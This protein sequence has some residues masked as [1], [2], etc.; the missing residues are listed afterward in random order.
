MMVLKCREKAGMFMLEDSFF[1]PRR[2]WKFIKL[3]QKFLDVRKQILKRPSV[4]NDHLIHHITHVLVIT[5]SSMHHTNQQSWQQ[6]NT[7]HHIHAHTH[8]QGKVEK[9]RTRMQAH[10]RVLAEISSTQE[11]IQLLNV[12]QSLTAFTDIFLERPQI[13]LRSPFQFQY[14][15]S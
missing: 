7:R 3:Q 8:K 1:R 11:N 2:I 13:P 12:H 4:I 9:I 15:L 6:S 14:S 10:S 5:V